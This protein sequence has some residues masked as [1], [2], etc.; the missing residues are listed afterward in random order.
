MTVVQLQG[1][2]SEAHSKEQVR[3]LTQAAEYAEIHYS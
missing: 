1:L 2:P 3:D